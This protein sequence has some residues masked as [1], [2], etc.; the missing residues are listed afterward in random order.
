MIGRAVVVL[1]ALAGCNEIYGLDATRLG[2]EG[3]VDGDG[4]L[5]GADNCVRIANPGQVDSDGDG[6]GDACGLICLA[7]DRT[8][9]DLDRDRIDDGCDPCPRAP[10]Q[11]AQ[12]RVL[13]ED[14]D[15]A[16]DACDNCPGTPNADQANG[17]NDALGDACDAGSG[18][19]GR[20]LFDPFWRLLPA[21]AATTWQVGDGIARATAGGELRLLGV[22]L[23]MSGQTWIVEAGVNL[24]GAP[25]SG[26]FGFD[27]AAGNGKIECV[28][29][30][31][32]NGFDLVVAGSTVLAVTAL[33]VTSGFVRL[34][35][36]IHVDS[37]S[38]YL[39]C[40]AAGTFVRASI[41]TSDAELRPFRMSS[42]L[43]V[44]HTYVDVSN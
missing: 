10:Q 22:E 36:Y 28:I 17:D 39:H 34:R 16:Y 35:A 3:D 44:E 21:W 38:K 4:V 40:E 2:G 26:R 6:K 30:R 37:V 14:A 33:P 5:D 32:V 7:G 1:A 9:K 42:S 20:I 15:G 11:D 41:S 43:P 25:T 18:A 23:A 19:Q 8:N 13:D 27:F 12:G 31:R 29:E 24:P